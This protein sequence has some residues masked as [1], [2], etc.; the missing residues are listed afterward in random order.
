MG[1][2]I[3]TLTVL[4]AYS[5]TDALRHTHTTH[6]HKHMN[7]HTHTHTHSHAHIH[8][9]THARMHIHT[10]CVTDRQMV[11]YNQQRKR[12]QADRQRKHGERQGQCAAPDNC[13]RSC[14]RLLFV[15]Q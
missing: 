2:V 8:A 9:C 1:Q 14:D 11:T 6:S 15:S 7:M 12:R 3:L 4:H 5:H 13:D 10:H